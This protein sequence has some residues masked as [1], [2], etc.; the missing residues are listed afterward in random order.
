MIKKKEKEE[1]DLEITEIE[2]F[3]EKNIEDI[4]E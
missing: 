3:Q 2:L 4:N 1:E